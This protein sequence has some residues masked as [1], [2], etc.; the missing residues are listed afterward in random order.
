MSALLARP[1]SIKNRRVALLSAASAVAMVVGAAAPQQ[2]R[3]ED[4]TWQPRTPGLTFFNAGN[5]SPAGGDLINVPVP[6]TA[7]AR[8]IYNNTTN[9]VGQ[10][11][12]FGAGTYYFVINGAQTEVSFYGSLKG[13]ESSEDQTQF[14]FLGSGL[15]GLNA[16]STYQGQQ[17][18]IR[19][20][21]VFTR[22][23]KRLMLTALLP[24]S[25]V[26]RWISARTSMLQSR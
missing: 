2:A 13:P 10:D 26:A 5:W 9:V 15:I 20:H 11:I 16:K 22:S 23:I 24:S 4:Y 14:T 3:A 12:R 25:T 7:G 19:L 21:L 8:F 6:P 1:V 17:S 18:S